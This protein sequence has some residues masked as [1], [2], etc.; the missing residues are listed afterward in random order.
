MYPLKLRIQTNA[1]QLFAMRRSNKAFAE[2]SKKVFQRD[3]YTCQFCGF[4]AKEYQEIINKDHNYRNN[5]L[6]NMVTACCLCTQCFFLNAVGVSYGGGALIHLDEM[7]QSDLN[8]LCHV[9]FCAI[10]NDT[11]YKDI[12][13]NTYRT[14]K[15]RSQAIEEEF[16]EGTS[17]PAIFS[18]LYLETSHN[19]KQQADELLTKMRLLPSRAR[20][21]TQIEHWANVALEEMSEEEMH[22]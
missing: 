15:L 7:S 21:R 12:S 22:G 4:Q 1:W 20:F 6:S 2:F 19:S 5:K 8:S 16:G 9:L 17:D 3:D 14:L 10:S 13:Q 18:Q 11:G